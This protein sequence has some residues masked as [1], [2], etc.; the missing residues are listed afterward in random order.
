[1]A[2]YIP[3]P[4]V[5]IDPRNEAELLN[6]ALKKVFQASNGTINDFSSG[7]PITALLEGQVFAQGEL[8]Y[9]LNR[10]PDAVITEWIGPFLGSMRQTGAASTVSLTF[11][12]QTRD[13]PFVVDS[14]FAVSTTP[15]LANGIDATFLT[16]T[17]LI[18]PPGEGTG[19]VSATCTILGAGGNVPADSVNRFA[20]NLA[21]LT[22]VTNVA[23]ASGGSDVET[24]QEVKQ[25]F[26]TLIRR[27]NPVSKEDW[28][29]FFIDLFGLGTVVSTVPRRSSQYEPLSPSDEYGHV[30]FF[31]LKPE[32][33]QPSSEDI[34]NINNLIKVSCPN[35][36]EAHVYPIEL[37]D[38]E[39]FAKFSYDADLGFTRNVE[40]LAET[41]R[42]YLGNI[43]TPDSYWPIDYSPSVGDI[44]GA[45]VNQ[46]GSFTSPDVLSL[47]AYFTPPGV[48]K[49]V[50][51]PG[52]LSSFVASETII[53]DDLIQQGNSYYPTV[54]GFSPQSGTQSS[55]EVKGNLVLSPVKSFS[56][57]VGSYSKNDV[58]LYNGAY[59]L[60]LEDFQ[61]GP[62]R[63]FESY[64]DS[65]NISPA[66][67]TLQ[68]WAGGLAL[69]T[70]DL[71][72]ATT[73]DFS[74]VTDLTSQ[75]LAWVPQTNFVVPTSTTT[76]ANAQT[77]N[78][79]SSVAATVSNAV[80]GTS[81][82]AGEYIRLEQT[83]ALRGVITLTY[84]VESDFT[85]SAT[86]DFSSVVREVSV[87]QDTEFSQL[88]YRYKSRFAIGEYLEDRS[89]G[90]YYQALKNFTPYTESVSKMVSDQYLLQIN[91]TP[92][93]FRPI[94][95]LVVG[96]VVS[97]INGRVT[98]RYEVTK[99]FTPIFEVFNYIEDSNFLVL[100]NDLVQSTADFYDPA[101]NTESIVFTETSGGLKFFRAMKPFTASSTTTSYTG[102]IASNTARLEELNGNLLQIVQKASCDETV[103]SRSGDSTSL[104][105]LGSCNFSFVPDNGLQ[106]ITQVVIEEDGN[107]SYSPS[108]KNLNPI[109]YGE[110]TYAL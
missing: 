100:R 63:S 82:T 50:L 11:T 78:F 3:I 17:T 48:S 107:T 65:N 92:A 54:V 64:Q 62:T 7:S 10:L 13:T 36:F 84:L 14:G 15:G 108:L 102:S 45:L 76:L 88:Q 86:Q 2:R 31:L 5:S 56:A 81:Y 41:L 80:D 89:T 19:T 9:Y 77:S 37:N 66:A 106:F 12:I 43:F 40:T 101:Y 32:S 58:I 34:K 67:K 29:N 60:V 30:S 47:S 75:P 73:T 21:G 51:N 52:F 71:V 95:R 38:V 97:L 70:N 18:I 104:S 74:T 55:E 26:Y 69:T 22:S 93:N 103:F 49:N 35:E 23:A 59:Y 46:I 57:T 68:V 25:R 6:A 8:L 39:I 16:D 33:Q 28:E 110:G 72:L 20:S 85:Y 53:P 109:D 105:S 90:S 4:P 98:Q 61:I 42:Q 83:D 44:Q 96:D 1:M 79:V 24:I 99:N 87:F 94:F 27:P 91:F